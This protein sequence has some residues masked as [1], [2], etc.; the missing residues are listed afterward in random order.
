[1]VEIQF[2]GI[3]Y[4]TSRHV[5]REGS[6]HHYVCSNSQQPLVLPYVMTMFLLVPKAKVYHIKW[7]WLFL[8]SSLVHAQIH[9][10]R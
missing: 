9:M 4:S 7:Q 1:L 5:A 6:Q 10:I 8:F 3:D 2:V